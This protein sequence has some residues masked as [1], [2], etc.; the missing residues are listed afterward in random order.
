[1]RHVEFGTTGRRSEIH[2]HEEV[3]NLIQHPMK[4]VEMLL[5]TGAWPSGVGYNK[6][7]QSEL[8]AKYTMK[9]ND[10]QDLRKDQ[11]SIK[12]F[13]IGMYCCQGKASIPLLSTL[14]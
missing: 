10:E 3:K 1:M 4:S 13:V 5:L 7:G 12:V 9:H 8:Q 14:I 2:F 6:H 11:S